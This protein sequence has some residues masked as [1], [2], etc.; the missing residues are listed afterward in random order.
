MKNERNSS[1]APIA[2]RQLLRG[3]LF[4]AAGLLAAGRPLLSA[5]PGAAL[6][7]AK[8]KAKA[9][10][11]IQ[12]WLWG[13]PSHLDTFDPKPDAGHDYCGP[14]N[15]PIDTNVP[16]MRISELLPELAKRADKF[17]LI[18]SMTHGN[19][20]HETAAYIVQTGR[21]PGGRDVFPSVGAVVALFRGYGAGCGH[22]GSGSSHGGGG[23]RNH[24]DRRGGRNRGAGI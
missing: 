22:R 8:A 23:R 16:G 20:G 1:A 3:G 19:N 4:G 7:P 17:S 15:K 11:V 18:R 9:K 10:S 24:N 2:R 14:L 6:P 12:I 5:L 21:M 13:G